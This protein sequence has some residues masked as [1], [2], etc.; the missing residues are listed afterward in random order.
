[1]GTA[2]PVETDSPQVSWT[3]KYPSLP[4]LL[5]FILT[6]LT[7]VLATLAFGKPSRWLG[8]A[9]P[10]VIGII[11]LILIALTGAQMAGRIKFFPVR[12]LLLLHKCLAV[13][14]S[15]LVIGTFS[16]GIL[17]MI[18]HN[19]P[20][21]TSLHGWVGL[22]V[23]ILSAVQFFMSLGVRD[24]ASIRTSHRVVGYLIVVLFIVQV[25]LGMGAAEIFEFLSGSE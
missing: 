18:L 10:A 1:M 23:A 9:I 19:R 17:L 3:K 22:A 13:T 14:F 20:I 24:R 4:F 2:Q 15:G 8:H 11:L 25:F 5:I 16:L 6:I 12:K 21:L 7:I